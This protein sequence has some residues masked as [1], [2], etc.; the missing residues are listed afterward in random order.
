[1]KK[2]SYSAMALAVSAALVLVACG[3]SGDDAPVTTT[4]VVTVDPAKET[5]GQCIASLPNDL[6]ASD[7]SE[8]DLA[9]FTWDG[10]KKYDS[11]G[12]G[13]FKENWLGGSFKHDYDV[14]AKLLNIEGES[15]LQTS[16]EYILNEDLDDKYN[17]TKYPLTIAAQEYR[18]P[19]GK[20]I[21]GWGEVATEQNG[22]ENYWQKR[23]VTTN[24]STEFSINDLVKDQPKNIEYTRKVTIS[25]LNGTGTDSIKSEYR[26]L[27]REKIETK[28]G[29]LEACVSQEKTNVAYKDDKDS[30]VSIW[31]EKRWHIP[32]LGYVKR[33]T[34]DQSFD[35]I[36]KAL[37][38]EEKRTY[39]IV[40]ARKNNKRYGSYDMWTGVLT[41]QQSNAVPQYSMCNYSVS[42]S[43]TGFLW[44][45]KP[46]AN[47]K[48][49]Y[50]V[51]DGS[52]IADI[53]VNY[54]GK[55]ALNNFKSEQ[56][57]NDSGVGSISWSQDINLDLNAKSLLGTYTRTE[58]R[59]GPAACEGLYPYSAKGTKVF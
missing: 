33:E 30:S 27:G 46:E 49:T 41:G 38:F 10:L 19:D 5:L 23:R 59:N 35:P 36:S 44:L 43:T 52:K 17:K 37:T 31:T 50:R 26:F 55:I 42:G 56:F 58:K 34:I 16:S 15:V 29:V 2:T 11:S 21:L 53:A 13:N 4:P 45:F 1:M 40:G 7:T 32:K 3:G 25:W 47:G 6:K 28:L 18:S 22:K 57:N 39:D 9:V 14:S 8:S 48:G 20:K 51:W 24:A 12:K 54:P